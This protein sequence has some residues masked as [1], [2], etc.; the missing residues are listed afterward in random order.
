MKTFIKKSIKE[1][2]KIKLIEEI[3]NKMF[4]KL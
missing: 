4:I 1:K 3:D 2:K